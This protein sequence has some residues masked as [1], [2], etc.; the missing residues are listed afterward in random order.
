[1]PA[2]VCPVCSGRIQLPDTPPPHA[3]VCTSCK[4]QIT[5]P[6]PSGGRVPPDLP[7]PAPLP[8]VRLPATADP[9]DP[10]RGEKRPGPYSYGDLDPKKVILVL[11][12]LVAAT[13][14]TLWLLR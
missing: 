11:A 4:T 14:L 6:V 12:I 8:I 5:M 9:T 10:G 7:T 2:V 13:A 1:M 3:V